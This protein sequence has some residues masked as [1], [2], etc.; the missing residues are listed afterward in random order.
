M[1]G[2]ASSQVALEDGISAATLEQLANMG[3]DVELVTG[4]QRAL[5]GRG[6]IILQDAESGALWGGSDPRADGC[7]IAQI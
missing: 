6:Q 4:H 1:G 5:F 3:H 2:S 7:A